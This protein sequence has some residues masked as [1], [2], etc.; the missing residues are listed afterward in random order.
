MTL[1]DFKS[2][3]GDRR[4]GIRSLPATLG[5]AAAARLACWVM[6]VPQ[7]IVARPARRLGPALARRHRGGLLAGPGGR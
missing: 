6:A 7:A 5:V 1:N 2:I 4:M 3:E